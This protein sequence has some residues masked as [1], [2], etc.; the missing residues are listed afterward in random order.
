MTRL[1]A[2]VVTLGVAALVACASPGGTTTPGGGAP[3]AAPPASGAVAKPAASGESAGGAPA[4]PSGASSGAPAASPA[5]QAP[6][7]LRKVRFAL[8]F[9]GAEAMPVFVG[10]DQ[11]LYRKYGLDVETTVLQSSAQIAP[12]MASGEIDLGL[13]AGSGAVDISLA[14]GDQVL[15]LSHSNFMHFQLIGRPDVQRIEDLRDKRIG[16]S[17]L[18]SSVHFGADWVVGKH[19]LEPTRDVL[20][21]QMGSSEAMLAGLTSGAVDAVISGPPQTFLAER[22]GYRRLADT[23]DYNIVY[24]Q[25]AIAVVR[26]TLAAKYDLIRDFIRGHVEAVGVTKRD[27]AL[28]TRLLG[29]RNQTDD[30]ELLDLTWEEWV[31]TVDPLLIPTVEAVQTVLDQRSSEIPAAKTANPRDFL[32]DRILR[33]L[34]A[35]GFLAQQLGPAR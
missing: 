2:F 6:A 29:E 26:G 12:A 34:Q 15:I 21:V 10:V 35:S 17:R 4:A 22:L 20:W 9:L 8:G 24:T 31:S 14:G 19:G 27:R 18:G 28:A 1:R 7:E 11:G 23:K 3:A 33:E 32:D 30:Q 13:S 5:A 16:I 25:A